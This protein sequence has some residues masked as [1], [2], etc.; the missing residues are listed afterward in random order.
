MFLYNLTLQPPSVITQAIIGN[1]S[2]RKSQELVLARATRLELVRADLTTG[3]LVTILSHDVFGV[4]RSLA[5]FRLTGT[6]KDYIVVGTDSGRITILA[7]DDDRNRFHAVQQETYGKSGV[8]RAVP[9]Q[10]LAADP[11]GRSLMIAAIEKQKMVYILNRDAT[12]DLTISSPLEAHTA[13][14]LVFACTA[15]DVG[16]ENPVFACLEVD[17]AEADEDTTGVTAAEAT[18]KVLTYYELDLGLNHVVRKWSD[19]V[20]HSANH[21]VPL[22]GGTLTD[23]ASEGPSGVLVCSAGYI[24]YRHQ[25]VTE[26][27][28]PIP[29]RQA[30]DHVADQAPLIVASVVHKMKSAFF[31]LVQTEAGDLF[32]ITVDYDG[33]TV[34]ALRIKYFDTIAPA[35]SLCVFKAG[36]LFAAAEFGN[37][38]LYQFEKLGDDDDVPEYSS[39]AMGEHD[40]PVHFEPRE[41]TNLAPID[42]LESL[43]PLLDTTVL[44]LAD[45]DTPQL[46]SLC[47]R[48]SQS[49]FK[50]LRHGLE[51]AEAAVSELPGNPMAIWSVKLSAQDSFDAYIIVAFVDATLVLSI[52][53][54]VEEVPDSGLLTSQT[55][56]TVHQLGDDTLVQVCPQGVRHVHADKRINEWR[57]PNNQEILKA[58]ANQRQ[59]VVVLSSGDVIYLE[60]NSSGQL[61]ESEEK[62]NLAEEVTALALA[63][64]PAGRQRCPFVAV[65]CADS[66]VRILSL[67]PASCLESQSMQVLNA[68][69][70]SLC[71]QEMAGHAAHPQATTMYL[72]VGLRNGVM[73]RTVVDPVGGQLSETRTRFLG[74][75]PVQLFAVVANGLPAILA[76]STRP[77][78]SYVY[79][80]RT[81]LAPLAYDALTYASAFASEPCPEGIVAISENT[82]RIVTIE[83]LGTS[84]NQASVPLKYTPRK[85]LHHPAH[86]HFVVYESDHRRTQPDDGAQ[87]SSES[88]TAGAQLAPAGCWC[89]CLRVL[90]P[91]NGETTWLM[92]L[93][94]HEAV[95]SMALIAF[96]SATEDE[97]PML[98]VGSASHVNLQ[99]RAFTAA[100]LSTYRFI[101]D[102]TQL[103]LV[104]RTDVDGIPGAITELQ[105]RALVGLGTTLRIY[106]LGKRKLLR[107]CQT[108][109]IPRGIVTLHTYGLRIIIGDLQES[110]HYAL[111]RPQENRIAIFADDLLPRWT[112]VTCPLDYDTMAG[113]DRFGNFYVLRLKDEVSHK[114]DE[115]TTGNLLYHEKSY[116][117]GA[118]NKLTHLANFYVGDTLTSLQKT[119]MVAGGREVLIYTTLLGSIGA[120]IPFAA[121]SDIEFFQT[122]EMHLR[123]A[124]PPLCG[125]DHL[126]YRS[127]YQPVKAVID[128]DLCEQFSL[129][130]LAKQD[131]VAE[132]MDR[133]ASEITKKL[134]DMRSMFAF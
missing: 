29:R 92:D 104:H 30:D 121:K 118:A 8:R 25:G 9:G 12:A 109:D 55:T 69:P 76:L 112:T 115:D 60:L 95:F 85:A 111:Y 110:M 88:G 119:V 7:Y 124:S 59:V 14:T 132:E 2:G 24:A 127:Y 103:E 98:V 133:T 19:P 126:A 38:T 31:A 6:T 62:A 52:G 83:R 91:F 99:T 23:T 33:E 131:Q 68:V 84:L 93:P 82:L 134:E 57:P 65:G 75:K 4:V 54:T 48:G 18:V 122:L 53:E 32:K 66:T 35:V 116:L 64:V 81:R 73:I 47:G 3:K 100:Y 36:F 41:L 114:I 40:A 49:S 1:F 117:Q 37:H 44:N 74:P 34:Q 28:I 67:E 50:V 10:Y 20:D 58:A 80:T 105:G 5:P 120:V 86:R 22:P 71:L 13:Q 63:P 70:H 16:F 61:E 101:A 11:R 21:L 125:R 79:Q 77:W 107:K 128:G 87:D 46:Y 130:P 42:E 26:H 39:A 15:L 17:Y 102:G 78:L 43:D 51:V 123:N 27:K 72:F 94:A 129:L 56:L 97:N 106:D 90:N 45:E 108:T 89:S 96:H 113:G